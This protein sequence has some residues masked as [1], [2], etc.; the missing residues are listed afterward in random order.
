MSIDKI[1]NRLHQ[2]DQLI[3]LKSTGTPKQ[4]AVKLNI[5]ERQVYHVI[6]NLRNYGAPI[7]YDRYRKTY[8]YTR[9]V[10]LKAIIR[11]DNILDDNTF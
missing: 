2:T 5:C 10:K 7:G 1:F 6:E 3:R 8:Y 9:P 11:I 4:L